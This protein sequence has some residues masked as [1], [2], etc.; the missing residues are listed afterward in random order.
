MA[1]MGNST[2]PQPTICVEGINFNDRF[3][4]ESMG[5]T[6]DGIEI[7]KDMIIK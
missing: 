2:L 3:E 5:I 4:T 1:A 7:S 6:I